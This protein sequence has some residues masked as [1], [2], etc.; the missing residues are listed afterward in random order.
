[1]TFIKSIL[2]LPVDTAFGHARHFLNNH[3]ISSSISL[4]PHSRSF[5]PG[6]II[7]SESFDLYK[8]GENGERY[9]VRN[10]IYVVEVQDGKV[11]VSSWG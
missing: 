2:A 1:M 3:G 5:N 11:I 9:S 4:R 7:A 6:D 10:D 8:E